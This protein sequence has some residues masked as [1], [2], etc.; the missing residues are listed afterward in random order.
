MNPTKLMSAALF[1]AACVTTTAL[2]QDDFGIESASPVVISDLVNPQPGMVFNVYPKIAINTRDGD[3]IPELKK[4]SSLSTGI[5]KNESFGNV[6]CKDVGGRFMVW[7]GFIKC[8]RSAIYTFILSK[9]ARINNLAATGYT[10]RINNMPVIP[11]GTN[12]TSCDVSL[13]VGWNKIE[14]ACS[15]RF[16]DPLRVS[17]KPKGSVSEP[18]VIAPKDLFHDQK[19]EEEW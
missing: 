11:I 16:D 6:M 18:R 5:D 19:V 13:K 12:T 17:Y 10:V 8:K 4:Q 15:F 3:F 2:A 1:V 14:I 7:E 9:P